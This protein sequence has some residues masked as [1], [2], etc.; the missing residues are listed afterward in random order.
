MKNRLFI[1]IA[2]F[3]FFNYFF[4]LKICHSQNN[5][6]HNAGFEDINFPSG[7]ELERTFEYLEVWEE[8]NN[9]DHCDDE[10]GAVDTLYEHSPDWFNITK[11][12]IKEYI[13]QQG[14][15]LINPN[16][17]ESFAGMGSCEL[18]EQDFF[19]SKPLTKGKYILS[20]YVRPILRSDLGFGHNG[21]YSDA[22]INVY[23]AKNKIKYDDWNCKYCEDCGCRND[24]KYCKLKDGLLQQID[25]AGQIPINLTDC[26]PGVWTKKIIQ[27][28]VT[29][30][31][32]DWIGFE[33]K[34][35][36][37]DG[38]V[39]VD[40][41]DLEPGCLSENCS[42]TAN[43]INISASNTHNESVPFIVFGLKNT[44][45]VKIEI[46]TML[47][48]KIWEKTIINPSD[49]VAWNGKTF[50]NSEAVIGDYGYKIYVTNDCNSD[51][52][53][54]GDF[55]KINFDP[56]IND[57]VLMNY[58]G[59]ITKAP[60]P[61]CTLVPD[62]IISNQILVQ[63]KTID[64]PLLFKAINSITATNVLIPTTNNVVFQAGNYIDISSEFILEDGAEFVAEI[65][66]CE[67]DLD[68]K[69]ILTF[70]YVDYS[71]FI[72]DTIRLF[73]FYENFNPPITYY[74]DFNN[75][76]FSNEKN[77]TIV[78]NASGIYNISL[79]INDINNM[80]KTFQKQ[81]TI[82]DS[83]GMY[84][85]I[86]K[87]IYDKKITTNL[88]SISLDE[89]KIKVFPNPSNGLIQIEYTYFE[90]LKVEID[91]YDL[92]G[93]KVLNKLINNPLG[94]MTFNTNLENGMYFYK[95]KIDEKNII[96]EKLIIIN[97]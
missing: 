60:I 44:T 89:F 62:I 17:G 36:S 28:D 93:R 24:N 52:L 56:T 33:F 3:I 66:P 7:W 29:E 80:T 82:N 23:L 46:W 5:F 58:D 30:K 13:P 79:T 97:K 53:F 6:T 84:D 54:T 76:E 38:Y 48:V 11:R 75:G 50:D 77:P 9:F 39:L 4:S 42:S 96:S 67:N 40:D 91:F 43:A 47:G 55:T 61:C 41:V 14:Y 70:D 21:S 15:F 49:R 22:H 74:W 73:S 20:L 1:F 83:I 88:K 72:N 86:S 59:G 90:D 78:Y 71:Y 64:E 63:D 95:I 65:V 85:N 92:S 2:L 32:Y 12:P 25:I 37:C 26:P 51:Q 34:D 19:N 45:K 18:I 31:F 10:F 16:N 94:F 87:K 68:L 81:I 57:P 8:S 69:K 27:I 35:P